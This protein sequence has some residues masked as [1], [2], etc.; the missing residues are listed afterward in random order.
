VASARGYPAN[1]FEMG[2]PDEMREY[3]ISSVRAAQTGTAAAPHCARPAILRSLVALQQLDGFV[4]ALQPD[5]Q[6]LQNLAVG[7]LVAP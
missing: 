6:K 4:D 1:L 5:V 7:H 3:F 2:R